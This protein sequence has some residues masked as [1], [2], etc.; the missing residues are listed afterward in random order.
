MIWEEQPLDFTRIG[1][2][3]TLI[4][5][6]VG[7]VI[8]GKDE[9]VELM[10]IALIASGHVLLEDVP[11]TGKTQLAK[12]LA[13]SLDGTMKRIQFTPD[14]LPSD[15]SGINFYNQ[16]LGEFEFRPG[17]L[18]AHIVLADEINRATP[19]TQSAL[20][21]SMEERQV[22]IDGE[23]RALE[24]PFLVIA[25]QNPVENQGTFPLPEAQLDRFLMK[26]SLGYP[27]AAEQ[28]Q[29]LK[30]YQQQD[31]LDQLLPVVGRAELLEAQRLFVQV[32]FSDELLQYLVQLAE[33]TRT[34][35]DAALGVSPRGV[36]ALMKAA[37]VYAALRGRDYVLPD[38]IKA[39]AG[40]VWA[41]R[42][43]LR[44][45]SRQQD[46]QVQTLLAGILAA[47]PVP[48]EVKLR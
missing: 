7:R 29:I 48:T 30:R 9:T 39:L 5:E 33:A 28:V 43:L 1:Q 11:G 44:T 40:P 37:Q 8:V 36:R 16:K 23:T 3:A 41:H 4:K 12:A 45:R 46:Q 24:A 18:F 31:P 13:R 47:T 35:A 10:V 20:L 42:I 14:L 27:S 22:S 2:I 21:E 17:P 38:D 34:H 15:V 32:R 19:R 26:L 6:N 25:T